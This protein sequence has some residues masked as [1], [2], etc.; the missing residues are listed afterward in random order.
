VR[1]KVYVAL[2]LGWSLTGYHVDA[3]SGSLSTK[4]PSP[5][6][7]H[8]TATGMALVE[9]GS[10]DPMYSTVTVNDSPAPIGCDGVITSSPPSRECS[11]SNPSTFRLWI[12]RPRRSRLNRERLC[13]AVAR[14]V[15]VASSRLVR[16]STVNSR[17]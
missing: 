1:W 11:A 16:G 14:I 13:V 17:S 5:V 2:S 15:A 10:G 9:R 12:C 8:P 7:I 3:P 4:L 6:A